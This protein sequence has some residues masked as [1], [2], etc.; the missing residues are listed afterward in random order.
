MV[1]Y[2]AYNALLLIW[3]YPVIVHACW[4]QGGFL[5]PTRTSGR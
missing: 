3:T 2:F 4:S 5:S 1:A